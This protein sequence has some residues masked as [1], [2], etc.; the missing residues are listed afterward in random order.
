MAKLKVASF[1]RPLEPIEWPDGTDQPVKHLTWAEQ[2]LLADME[3]G[4]SSVRDAMPKV[5]VALLPGRT[6]DEIRTVLDADAMR[7]VIAYASGKY[8]EAMRA[9]EEASGKAT[10]AA[11]LS[12]PATP[13]PTSSPASPAPTAAPCGAS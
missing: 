4:E 13:S 2:E 3:N 12:P 1:V 6:W 7:A 9:M 10:G 5:M 8:E 11:P